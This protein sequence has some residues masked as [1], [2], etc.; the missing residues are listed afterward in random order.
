MKRLQTILL[1]LIPCI[2]L[3]G[4]INISDSTVSVSGHWNRGDNQ[5]YTI[6]QKRIKIKD[7]DTI[8]KEVVRYNVDLVIVDSVSGSYKIDWRYYDQHNTMSEKGIFRITT[9]DKGA[10]Q[11]VEEYG[12]GNP[13][14]H[15]DIDQFFIYYGAN[16]KLGEVI[17]STI[18]APNPYSEDLLDAE[19]SVWLDEILLS[20]N[21]YV[22]QMSQT[23]DSEQLANVAYKYLT[24]VS[25]STG[26]TPPDRGDFQK[27]NNTTRIISW[28]HESGWLIYSIEMK[29]IKAG[30]MSIIEERRIEMQ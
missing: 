18:K 6:R 17:T 13:V 27:F 23:I 4:Q 11:K 30:N 29:V 28:I 12:Q 22:M 24:L 14:A 10:L 21:T 1:M 16:V 2:S 25:E 20:D 26:E 19:I 9:N 7:S 3:Y 8:S 5:A 15:K